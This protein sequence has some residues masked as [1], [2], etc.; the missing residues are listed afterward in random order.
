M[1][2]TNNFKNDRP[3]RRR[4]NIEA[5][6]SATI[7]SATPLWWNVAL[8]SWTRDDLVVLA[9][10][11]IPGG[12]EYTGEAPR[13]VLVGMIEYQLRERGTWSWRWLIAAC[14][15]APEVIFA[16]AAAAN[17][18]AEEYVGGL[19]SVP[20]GERRKKTLQAM[21]GL[22]AASCRVAKYLQNFN[23]PEN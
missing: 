18:A 1:I 4:Q 9:E 19:L 16:E 6:A 22:V 21:S 5:I 10:V 11:L 2:V 17:P 3:E 12:D 8:E 7:A 15:R 13:A 14:R 20:F 23:N